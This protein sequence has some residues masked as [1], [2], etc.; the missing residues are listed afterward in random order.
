MLLD[1]KSDEA[2]STAPVLSPKAEQLPIILPAAEAPSDDIENNAGEE[3]EELDA[4]EAVFSDE[5]NDQEKES[6]SKSKFKPIEREDEEGT[7]GD[8]TIRGVDVVELEEFQ[9]IDNTLLRDNILKLKNE[10]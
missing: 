7:K 8:E 6:S 4:D 2:S 9:S 5:E 1:S 10:R 3:T